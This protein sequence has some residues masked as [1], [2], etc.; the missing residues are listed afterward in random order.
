MDTSL[1][2]E[3]EICASIHRIELDSG[4]LDLVLSCARIFGLAK[5]LPHAPSSELVEAFLELRGAELSPNLVD[6]FLFP[7][8]SQIL[9]RKTG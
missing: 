9:S 3:Q 6:Y 5:N 2:T 4:S 7:K 1:T 8:A